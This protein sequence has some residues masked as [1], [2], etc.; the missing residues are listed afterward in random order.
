MA[1]GVDLGARSRVDPAGGR[2]V[3]QRKTEVPASRTRA[4]YARD[5]SPHN[6][7]GQRYRR[8]R[9]SGRY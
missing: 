9:R 8:S 2:G 1:R 3:T 5:C 6:G 4:K 7:G